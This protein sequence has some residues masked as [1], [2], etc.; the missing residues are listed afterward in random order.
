MV[1]ECY[2]MQQLMDTIQKMI[3]SC[4]QQSTLILANRKRTVVHIEKE[5][6]SC[7]Y[8][9]M[10]IHGDKSQRERQHSLKM[11]NSKKVSVLV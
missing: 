2:K 3:P 11:F 4:K 5:L 6:I 1:E 8:N 7:G 9:A 10:S